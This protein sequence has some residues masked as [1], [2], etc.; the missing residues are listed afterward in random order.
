MGAFP[1]STDSEAWN[2]TKGMSNCPADQTPPT[3]D[4]RWGLA[5]TAGALSWW[6][7]DSNGYGTYLD[8]KAGSKLIIMARRFFEEFSLESFSHIDLY[9]G[10]WRLDEPHEDRWDLEAASASWDAIVGVLIF[11]FPYFYE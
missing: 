7:I 9:L 2:S 6:H 11:F 1:I 5:A 8:P 10:K 3:G 4:L